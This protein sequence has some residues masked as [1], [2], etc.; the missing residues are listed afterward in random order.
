MSR[1]VQA[2]THLLNN[3]IKYTP[4]N[5]TITITGRN[6]MRG[7]QIAKVELIVTDTGIGIDPKDHKRIFEKFY[8]I[9]N[10]KHHSTGDVKFKGAGLG[11]GLSLVDGIVTAHGGQVWVESPEHN[12][13]TCPGSQFHLILPIQSPAEE[14]K[15]TP[16]TP[17][18]M[19]ET[20]HWRGDEMKLVKEKVAQLKDEDKTR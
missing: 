3:A 9:G 10:V 5:G 4:D 19:A 17:S 11:L 15:P 8:R 13:E 16:A 12:E 20:R 1:L 7:G 18:S 6:I 14:S 2:V